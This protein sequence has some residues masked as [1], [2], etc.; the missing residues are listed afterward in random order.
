MFQPMSIICYG[1]EEIELVEHDSYHEKTCSTFKP[2][3]TVT[4]EPVSTET[5][6]SS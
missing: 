2:E 5:A 3:Q 6:S 1:N 4:D